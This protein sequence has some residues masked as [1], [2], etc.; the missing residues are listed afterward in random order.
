LK[1]F[2]I[3]KPEEIKSGLNT[4]AY[5]L[6]TEEVLEGMGKN[7]D[8]VMELFT[9]S[10][11]DENY[12]FGVVLGIYEVAKLLEGLPVDVYAMDE[13]EIFFPYEPVLQIRGKYK[14]FA[15]YETTILGFISFMSGI[16]T[17]SARVRIADKR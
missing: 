16:G 5:F 4:D 11:P 1:E 8:V 6:R 3:A 12:Q 14:D 13:G 2:L 17:K 10:F 15:R 9:K 7:P